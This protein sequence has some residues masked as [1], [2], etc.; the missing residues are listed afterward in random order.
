M[1]L[2]A[3]VDALSRGRAFVD[4][5][6]WK[7]LAVRGGDARTWLNDLVSADLRG[8]R[9]GHGCRSLLLSPT[10]GVRAE[11]GVAI[12]DDA[13]LLL[14]DPL[15]PRSV[16]D[17]LAPYVLSSDVRLADETDE[18]ALVAFPRDPGDLHVGAPTVDRVSPSCAGDTGGVDLLA[19]A[20]VRGAL[21][22]ELAAAHESAGPDAL[23]AWRVAAGVPRVAVDASAADLPDEIGLAGAVSGD[24]GCY[25]GQEAV[26]KA[27]NLGH[28]RRV[29]LHLA[30]EA[31]V[32]AGD[33]VLA[34]GA[35]VGVVTSAARVNGAWIALVR[36]QWDARE[37][38]LHAA[39][40]AGMR[41]VPGRGER[42]GVT[43]PL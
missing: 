37:L 42:P 5:S 25:L 7:K 4:L 41:R 23:E 28:P 16:G 18:L 29:L 20:E 43:S 2:D 1:S 21:V 11:F 3:S 40:G 14:Q 36:V 12:R 9:P 17:L 10:G 39:S 22:A 38:P 13:I 31:P 32:E 27:R 33:E 26:A 8:L 24:K 35:A 6:D 19:P 15:Q 34:D 30:A